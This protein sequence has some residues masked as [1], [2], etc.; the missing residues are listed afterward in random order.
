MV[1]YF[2]SPARNFRP[3][4]Q[5]LAQLHDN[6]FLSKHL[7]SS[8]RKQVLVEIEN[9]LSKPERCPSNHYIMGDSIVP[10]SD[11]NPTKPRQ[12]LLVSC[13]YYLKC[14]FYF[15]S[16]GKAVSVSFLLVGGGFC[17]SCFV[18]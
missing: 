10:V 11:L 5:R 4:G 16:N 14:Y 7:Y 17:F 18:L 9:L 1:I 2:L 6:N 12:N 3:G 13:I 15:S 8:E